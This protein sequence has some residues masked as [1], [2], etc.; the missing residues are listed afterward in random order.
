MTT[1]VLLCPL[2]V[3][4]RIVAVEVTMRV[5]VA[6]IA[7]TAFGFLLSNTPA[8]AFAFAVTADTFDFV[9]LASGTIV[10]VAAA[11]ADG[12]GCGC[13]GRSNDTG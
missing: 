6:R 9:G 11:A 1:M 5:V 10:V 2:L 8:F 12:C 3:L 4:L 7:C 13:G